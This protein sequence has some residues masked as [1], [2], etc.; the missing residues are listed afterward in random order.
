[1]VNGIGEILQATKGHGVE[2]T[3]DAQRVTIE[4]SVDTG[5]I[6]GDGGDSTKACQMSTE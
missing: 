6:N 2:E 4:G 3:T 1:M 5:R